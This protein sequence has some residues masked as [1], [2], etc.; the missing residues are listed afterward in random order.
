MAIRNLPGFA[1]FFPLDTM[2]LEVKAAGP[3]SHPLSEQTAASERLTLE[4]FRNDHD[5][6]DTYSDMNISV[7][8]AGEL[9]HDKTFARELGLPTEGISPARLI[10]CAYSLGGASNLQKLEGVFCACLYDKLQAKIFLFRDDSGFKYLYYRFDPKTGLTFATDLKL[11]LSRPGIIKK[12][13]HRSLHE[14]LRTLEIYPPNTIFENV[15]AVDPGS[16][17]RFDGKNVTLIPPPDLEPIDT[18]SLSFDEAAQTVEELLKESIGTR[19]AGKCLPAFFLSGGI[20]SSLLCSI[21]SEL[22]GKGIN[23]FTVGFKEQHFDET[24]TAAAIAR[25]LGIHH[26]ELYFEIGDYE[27]CFEKLACLSDQPFSDPAGMATFLAFERLS[28]MGYVAAID[29]TGADTLVGTMP[30]RYKRIAVQ[31]GTLLPLKGRK[32]ISKILK[33]MPRVADYSKIFDF[34]EPHDLLIRWP[35]WRSNEIEQLCGEPVSLDHTRLYQIYASY[36]RS[37]HF[38]RYSAIIRNTSDDRIHEA[39]RHTG[40]RARFPYWDRDL[41]CF[42]KSLKREYLYTNDEPKRILRHLLGQRI[43]KALWDSPKR[44]FTFP[45]IEFQRRNGCALLKDHLCRQELDKHGLF[46]FSI[47]EHHLSRFL[48]GDNAVAFRVWGL[49]IFQAWY[50]NHFH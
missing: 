16:L 24:S 31:Y 29:G 49:L 32:V 30:P 23:A 25:H 12:L 19:L 45:F 38:E 15:Y 46:D 10:A 43:P 21:A 7:V 48:S 35:A 28:Q 9:Y 8:F 34:D 5:D 3:A 33:Q 26:H 44:P 37:A 27:G 20:D 50:R 36:P 39:G 11:L 41:G 2:S 18:Y 47:I 40:V 4:F 13:S 6:I 22:A 17:L 1:G 42:I 14:F